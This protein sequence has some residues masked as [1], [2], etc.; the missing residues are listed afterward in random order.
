[1]DWDRDS[2][3]FDRC[4]PDRSRSVPG[5]FARIGREVENEHFFKVDLYFQKALGMGLP[6]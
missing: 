1:M 2:V 5:D 6:D 3:Y 4:T